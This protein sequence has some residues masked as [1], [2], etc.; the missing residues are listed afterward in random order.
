MR[1]LRRK[2]MYA[3]VDGQRQFLRNRHLANVSIDITDRSAT[4]AAYSLR[5]CFFFERKTLYV[6]LNSIGVLSNLI[7]CAVVVN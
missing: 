1:K 2:M 4:V 3:Q 6:Y 5:K 7:Q